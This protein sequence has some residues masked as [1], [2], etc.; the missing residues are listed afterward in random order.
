[1]AELVDALDSKSNGSNTVRVRFSLRPPRK[2]NI[3]NYFYEISLR[4]NLLKNSIRNLLKNNDQDKN[5]K[6]IEKYFQNKKGIYVDVGSYHP[7][8]ISNTLNLYKNGWKGIN[9][10]ISKK[11]IDLFKLA[12]PNDTNLNLA[13]GSKNKNA[14]FF[15][16]KDLSMVNSLNKNFFIKMSKKKAK[17]KKIKMRTLD[18]ILNKFLRKKNINFL[19]I[20]AEGNDYDVLKGINLKKFNVE[21]ILIEGHAYNLNLKKKCGKMLKYL[22]KNNFKLIYGSF[23]GNGIFKNKRFSYND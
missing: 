5:K 17:S 6:F 23:P 12:R 11:T 22:N 14:Y 7:I 13:A 8:R 1:M 10:D 21:I 4:L 9:I 20:D 3:M 18:F 16:D 2:K 19:D 15:Y